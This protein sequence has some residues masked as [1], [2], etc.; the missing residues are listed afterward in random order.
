MS[1]DDKFLA[2]Y[3]GSDDDVRIFDLQS[4]HLYARL[5]HTANGVYSVSHFAPTADSWL[6]GM[7]K[8]KLSSGTWTAVPVYGIREFVIG[9]GL[10]VWHSLRKAIW[11]RGW[12]VSISVSIEHQ[13]APLTRILPRQHP[14][15]RYTSHGLKMENNC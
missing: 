4:G 13:D 15:G 5:K 2:V 3:A 6:L 9:Y 1:L 12:E 7:K 14:A 8:A 11:L 10:I